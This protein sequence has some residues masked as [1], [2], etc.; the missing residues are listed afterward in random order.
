MSRILLGCVFT[1]A[2]ASTVT[3]KGSEPADTDSTS[4]N[5]TRNPNPNDAGPGKAWRRDAGFGMNS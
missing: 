2:L 4:T 3:V 5:T 1:A